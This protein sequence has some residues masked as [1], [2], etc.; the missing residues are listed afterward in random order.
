MAS[1]GRVRYARGAERRSALV[2][3]AADVL[4]EHGVTAL[5]HRA[6]AARAGL[7][8]ASTTYYFA[9]VVELRDEALHCVAEMWLAR[10]RGAL[11]ALPSVWTGLRQPRPWSASSGQRPPMSSCC[12]ST[13]A[14]SMR[15]GTSGCARSSSPATPAWTSSYERCCC[16]QPPGGGRARIGL[17]LAV[18]DGAAVT[19]L[20]E[21]APARRRGPHRARQ[22]AAALLR[23]TCR[24]GTT[25][26]CRTVEGL[27]GRATTEGVQMSKYLV[28]I[29][30]DETAYAT[31]RRT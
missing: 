2:S 1:D 16:V 13:R 7:P 26:R 23:S 5:S 22:A 29:Y 14:T 20:A 12:C 21:G 18:T 3:A 15:A 25:S 11:D 6:V 27:T 31:R 30:E 28:L 10:A 8:L 24:C 9:S 4:L 19:A 17:V